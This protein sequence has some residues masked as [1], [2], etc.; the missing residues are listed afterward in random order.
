MKKILLILMLFP[1][2]AFS[3]GTRMQDY[4]ATTT[5]STND[6]VTVVLDPDGTP[7]TRRASIAALFTAGGITINGTNVGIGVSS[8]ATKLDVNGEITTHGSGSAVTFSGGGILDGA[9]T[10]QIAVT[11][12]FIPGK[13]TSNPCSSGTPE[14]GLFYNNTSHYPCFCNGTTGVK[15]TDNSTSCF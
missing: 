10:N 9:T 6:I 7:V 11:G 4:T 12:I 3:A 8:P 14:G 2:L 5:T 15:L 13:V 1:T